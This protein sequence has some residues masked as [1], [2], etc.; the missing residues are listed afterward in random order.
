[1][2]NSKLKISTYYNISQLRLES[3][4]D[5]KVQSSKLRNIS[6]AN[7][8]GDKKIENV[9]ELLKRLD[10]IESYFAIPGLSKMGLLFE[11]LERQEYTAF[12]HKIAEI[13]KLLVSDKYR[14]KKNILKFYLLKIFL[15]KKKI[16]FAPI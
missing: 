7:L 10:C 13:T 3:W 2:I 14:R 6:N 11:M 9:K 5:L 15:Y 1:M 16:N 4:T 12:A 8:E